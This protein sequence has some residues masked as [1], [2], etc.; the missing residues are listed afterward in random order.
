MFS[1][2]GND[3]FQIIAITIVVLN[4][5][6]SKQLEVGKINYLKPVNLQKQANG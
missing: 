4:H 1:N 3:K 2:E 5:N 6:V